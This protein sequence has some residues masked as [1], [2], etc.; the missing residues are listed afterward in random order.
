MFL[1]TTHCYSFIVWHWLPLP[2][3]PITKD[4]QYYSFITVWCVVE[5]YLRVSGAVYA[6]RSGL[7]TAFS[8]LSG[9]PFFRFLSSFFCGVPLLRFFGG[10]A[11]KSAFTH[12]T[13]SD[14]ELV[15]GVVIAVCGW[16]SEPEIACLCPQ[17]ST[18]SSTTRNAGKLTNAISATIASRP[19]SARGQEQ[20]LVS[21]RLKNKKNPAWTMY[22]F[23]DDKNIYR[24]IYVFKDL[25]LNS[26]LARRHCMSNYF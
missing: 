9:D 17:L 24:Y 25:L 16:K 8:L 13:A 18:I 5:V 21:V 1:K 4:C 2:L 15:L 14:H 6:H 26:K 7:S 3:S 20:F 22:W 10:I 23:V 19:V 11:M 12:S